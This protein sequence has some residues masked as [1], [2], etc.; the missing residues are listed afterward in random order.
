MQLCCVDRSEE[1]ACTTPRKHSESSQSHL[2][3]SC[4]FSEDTGQ[5]DDNQISPASVL[6]EPARTPLKVL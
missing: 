1:E 3:A 5:A 6:P 2:A 4:S